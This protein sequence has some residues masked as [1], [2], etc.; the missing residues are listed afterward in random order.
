MAA[1]STAR[2]ENPQEYFRHV[3]RLIADAAE[4]LD[5]AHAA[6]IVHRDIKPGNLLLDADGKVHVTDF[7]LAR[8][9]ADAGVTLTGDILGTLRESR[10]S[11]CL[12]SR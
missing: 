6:G 8:L 3:A 2:T 7:G 11:R 5:Y 4:A 9:E 12:P 1:L 10:L